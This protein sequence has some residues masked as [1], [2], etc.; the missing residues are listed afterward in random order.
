MRTTRFTLT[1]RELGVL[2]PDL[3]NPRQIDLL[4]AA[5]LRR[6]RC[7]DATIDSVGLDIISGGSEVE[8]SVMAPR[9][10]SQNDINHWL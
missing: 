5:I 4:E 10:V 3:M 8:I 1:T 9:A 7:Q 2:Y 6:L